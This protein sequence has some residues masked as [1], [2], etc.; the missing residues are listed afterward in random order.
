MSIYIKIHSS[1]RTVIALCDANILGKKFEEGKLQLDIR[2]NFYR[3]EKIDENELIEIMQEQAKE[4]ATFNIA[5]EKAIAAAL[6]AKIID[7][8]CIGSVQGIP[9]AL[10]L[11]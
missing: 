1:Y 4:D 9:F 6:K 7:G 8:G 3:G 11:L 2:E 10:K 5:G